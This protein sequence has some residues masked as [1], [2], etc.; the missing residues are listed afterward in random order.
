MRADLEVICGERHEVVV[1]RVHHDVSAQ[2]SQLD[3]VLLPRFGPPVRPRVRDHHRVD[4]GNDLGE[5]NVEV[6]MELAPVFGEVYR[7]P[8][9]GDLREVR[10]RVLGNVIGCEYGPGVEKC[11]AFW[12]RLDDF[13]LVQADSEHLGG[14]VLVFAVPIPMRGV[15]DRGE[16]LNDEHNTCIEVGSPSAKR[17]REVTPPRRLQE[18]TRTNYSSVDTRIPQSRE[19][20][21]RE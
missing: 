5:A 18:L 13:R 21:Q 16:H 3:E 2:I 9:A 11:P 10:S 7:S 6:G 17:R 12:S 1:V 4:T 19:G 14:P 8:A 15:N 20:G